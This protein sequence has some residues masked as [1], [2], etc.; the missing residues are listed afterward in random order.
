MFL[1]NNTG[2]YIP[3]QLLIIDFK[4]LLYVANNTITLL[5]LN[6]YQLD[7][8]YKLLIFIQS[9]LIVLKLLTSIYTYVLIYL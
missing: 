1:S 9:L 3:W 8:L 5:F 7:Q 6:Y 4:I 2:Q